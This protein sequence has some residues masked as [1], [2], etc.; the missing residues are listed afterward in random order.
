MQHNAFT[1]MWL[2]AKRDNKKVNNKNKKA[3]AQQVSLGGAA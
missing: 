1:S 2:Q 3:K